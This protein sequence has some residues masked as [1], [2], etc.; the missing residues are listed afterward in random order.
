MGC[1][2]CKGVESCSS[3][4]CSQRTTTLQFEQQGSPF[5]PTPHEGDGSNDSSI[6]QTLS[7]GDSISNN[8]TTTWAKKSNKYIC[9]KQI[10][11]GHFGSV[12]VATTP[13]GA[14]V[15]IKKLHHQHHHQDPSTTEI[16]RRDD[17]ETLQ[18]QEISALQKCLGHPCIVQL[19]D[20]VRKLF[21]TQHQH[22][23]IITE[24]IDG[25]HWGSSPLTERQGSVPMTHKRLNHIRGILRDILLALHHLHDVVGIAH[26][27]IKPENI[28]VLNHTTTNQGKED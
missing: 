25:S 13:T 15:A 5:D 9:Q 22:T 16:E 28:L 8:V 23:C 11:S 14:Q 3:S 12:F 26:M 24:Y 21:N 19:I 6:G 27:D 4:S 7:L 2:P 18:Q 1:T 20:V 17:A 10:G